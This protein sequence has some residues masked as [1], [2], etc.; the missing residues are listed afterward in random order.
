M[1]EKLNYNNWVIEKLNVIDVNLDKE[2]TKNDLYTLKMLMKLGS[3]G[4]SYEEILEL[5]KKYFNELW[6]I[7]SALDYDWISWEEAF[8]MVDKLENIREIDKVLIK[9]LLSVYYEVK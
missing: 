5:D 8:E 4:F 1:W 9:F 6:P 3:E 2:N 7:I